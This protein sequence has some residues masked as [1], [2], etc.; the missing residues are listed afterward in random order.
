MSYAKSNYSED[1][2]YTRKHFFMKEHTCYNL[3]ILEWVKKRNLVLGLTQENSM[4]FLVQDCLLY[5]C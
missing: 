5:I 1:Y 2:C 3:K 4:E